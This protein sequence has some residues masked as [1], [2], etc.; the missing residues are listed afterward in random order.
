MTDRT[1][2]TPQSTELYVVIGAGSVQVDAAETD[3]TEVRVE[4]QHAEQTRIEHDGRTVSVIGPRIGPFAGD[5]QLHV[6]VTLPLGSRVVTK[7]GSA[8]LTVS[9]EI[10][11]ADLKSGSGDISIETLVGA[12]T[13]ATG[14]GDISID[15]AEGHLKLQ[16]GSG[17]IRL[18]AAFAETSI[19]TGSGD[20][21]ITEARSTTVVKTGSGDLHVERAGTDT[22]FK[23]GSGDLRVGEVGGGRVVTKGASGEVQIG[24]RA[25]IPV[26]TDVHTVS[27]HIRS[28]LQGAGE[29]GPG[30][31]HV[32]LRTTTVSGD[33]T[34][35]EV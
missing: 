7:L 24:V 2:E 23:T 34:F 31:H 21:S 12:S 11:A 33:I 27:G 18:G 30:Q 14:S 1:F 5:R 8:D 15:R 13:L 9:G 25:G 35:T 20:V 10:G 17:E 28:T 4:G 22:S 26:W 3:T 19:S 32:E 16:S 29:P 6:A